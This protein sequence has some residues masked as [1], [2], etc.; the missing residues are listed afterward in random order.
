MFL[1]RNQEPVYA[2][3]DPDG[4][5]E[6]RVCPQRFTRIAFVHEKDRRAKPKKS[7]LAAKTETVDATLKPDEVVRL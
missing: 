4:K 7:L 6:N 2:V 3:T 1:K 5:F